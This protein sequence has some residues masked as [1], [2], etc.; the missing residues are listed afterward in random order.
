MSLACSADPPENRLLSSACS[1]IEGDAGS[2]LCTSLAQIQNS[3]V[4]EL[5]SVPHI[6]DILTTLSK[7]SSA[8]SGFWQDPTQLAHL[9][10]H[11]WKRSTVRSRRTPSPLRMV[12]T[13]AQNGWTA[14]PLAAFLS[15]CSGWVSGVLTDDVRA[16]RAMTRPSRKFLGALNLTFDSWGS[17]GLNGS[18]VAEQTGRPVPFD[19][20]FISGGRYSKVETQYTAL[21]PWCSAM[22]FYGTMQHAH[23]DTPAAGA[24][25]TG[26]GVVGFWT[27][28]L[29]EAP[30]S[31]TFEILSGS[32][33]S[34]PSSRP[35]IGGIGMLSANEQGNVLTARP[36]SEWAAWHRSGPDS[37]WQHLC[38]HRKHL[39]RVD[40][41]ANAS[42]PTQHR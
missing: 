19:L 26:G 39:C 3:T 20:C 13:G 38:S 16:E 34:D 18:Q 32:V 1:K 31:R 41:A 29:E 9:F 10:V 36:P 4:D 40:E 14:F 6:A 28:L 37:L 5:V 42:L 15:R 30:P 33:A 8:L 22:V 7:R 25:A 2:R 23:V 17:A 21:A 35:T 27:H 12:F 24:T 11:L